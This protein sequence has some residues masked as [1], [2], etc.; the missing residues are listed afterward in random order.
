[1]ENKKRET[2]IQILL[3]DITKN[4]QVQAIV[5]AA[6]PQLLGGSGVNGAIQKAAG[7]MLLQECIKLGGCPVGHA[8]I[9]NAY[10]LPCEYVIHTPGPIY[11]LN[12]PQQGGLL[13]LCY[14]NCLNLAHTHHIHSL[15]FPS[16]ST[17]IYG[18]PVQEA[19]Q[20]ALKT[21]WEYVKKHPFVFEKILFILYDKQTYQTYLQSAAALSIPFSQ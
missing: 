9:T 17:G 20:I 7:P 2:K 15:A 16:I 11:S 12:N 10:K 18:Y 21:V 13:A 19:S 4:H 8:K 1:M 6:N 5:N 14:I 3:G